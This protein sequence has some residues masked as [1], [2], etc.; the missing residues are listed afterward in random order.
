MCVLSIPNSHRIHIFPFKATL[1]RD[2]FT[3]KPKD[4]STGTLGALVPFLLD[5]QT[6]IC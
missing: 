2:M 1:K 4:K 3:K 5:I 6:F